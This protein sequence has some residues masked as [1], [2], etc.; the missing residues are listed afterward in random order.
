MLDMMITG[1]TGPVLEND[2]NR[3]EVAY[4]DANFSANYMTRAWDT[5]A[6]PTSPGPGS[7]WIGLTTE[8]A[9]T[10]VVPEPMTIGLLATGLVGIAGVARRRRHKGLAD[11][12]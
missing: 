12:C 1:Q 2:F 6:G 3:N 11:D 4:F 5:P 9:S 10:S 8:F 7:D